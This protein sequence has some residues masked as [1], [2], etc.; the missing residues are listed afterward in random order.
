M[1]NFADTLEEMGRHDEAAV[2]WRAYV[3]GDPVSEWGTYARKRLG[4]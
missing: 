3:A 1:F 2:H 4:S